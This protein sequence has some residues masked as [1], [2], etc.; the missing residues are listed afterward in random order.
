MQPKRLGHLPPGLAA[1]RI[2]L[3]ILCF[4]EAFAPEVVPL[5]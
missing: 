3:F 2:G 4:V 5:S 1:A